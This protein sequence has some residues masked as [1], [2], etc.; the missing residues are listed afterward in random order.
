MVENKMFEDKKIIV[1]TD[2][3]SRGNPGP[4]AIGVVV[5]DKEY[6]EYIGLGTNNQAEYKAIIFALKKIRQIIGKKKSKESEIEI[7]TDSELIVNHL[8][9]RYK[10]LEP[11]LQLLFLE[12]WNLRLDFKSVDFK[13]IPRTK[14]KKADL[15]V[16]NVL[17]NH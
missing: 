1:Y 2:G 13:Y 12:V 8:G 7:R 4:S 11:D 10:I 16:N 15:L 14:N 6:G 3:G 17:D 9:G 5:V